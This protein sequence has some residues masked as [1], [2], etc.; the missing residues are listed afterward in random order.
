M[1]NHHFLLII[2]KDTHPLGVKTSLAVITILLPHLS[3]SVKNYY[4]SLF[5][6]LVHIL[7]WESMFLKLDGICK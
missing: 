2:Q 1:G 3:Q 7:K 4:N 5:R 6:I